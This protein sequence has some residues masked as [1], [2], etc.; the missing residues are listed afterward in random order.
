MH[1][2]SKGVDIMEHKPYEFPQEM[3]AKDQKLDKG[4]II[5]VVEN[6][7]EVRK[8]EQSTREHS[9]WEYRGKKFEN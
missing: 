7:I 3:P 2:T 8:A 1:T 4:V 6:E 5:D 9:M